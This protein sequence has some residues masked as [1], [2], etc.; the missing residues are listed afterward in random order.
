[1]VSL[2]H[3]LCGGTFHVINRILSPPKQTIMEFLESIEGFSTLALLL[4]AT[5]LDRRLMN[6]DFQH[7][8][9]APTD[10]AF[11]RMGQ[12]FLFQLLEDLEMSTA[13]LKMHIMSGAVCCSQL[14]GDLLSGRQQSRAIDG[15]LLRMERSRHGSLLVGGARIVDCDIMATN[16]IVHMTDA[17]VSPDSWAMHRDGLKNNVFVKF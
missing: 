11:H 14:T 12:D 3:K 8:L 17:I 9:L 13:L 5:G 4:K 15:F 10:D 6:L 2:N 7:T 16:G 1:M